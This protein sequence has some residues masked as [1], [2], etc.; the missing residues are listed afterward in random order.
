MARKSGLGKGLGALMGDAVLESGNTQGTETVLQLS[1]MEP[2]PNQPR[3]NF[4][5]EALESLTDSIKKEG[6]LQPIL[7]R[8][9]GDT[10]Q[11]VAGERRYHAC[12]NAGL[13]E[14]PVRIVEMDDAQT[15]RV[16]LI[17]N[18]Q[19]SDLNAIEEAKGY[20]ELMDSGAVKTQAEVAEA[21]SKSRSAVTNALRLLELPE[22]V[23]T[24]VYD[25]KL[26]AGHARAILA[27]KEE[28]QQ[29]KLADKIVASNLSVRDAERLARLSNATEVEKTKKPEVP[30]S[31]KLVAK[32]L[33]RRLSTTVRVK[34]AKG[35]NRI[36]ID[37][38][39]EDD[40]KRI[41]DIMKRADID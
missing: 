24:L 34:A 27:V 7:V 36:E 40:L 32:E 12:K 35:K 39:D 5:K 41:F 17:E 22:Y 29:V 4:E 26:S 25:G 10:Y 21:V 1:E 28:S 8:K 6:L 38:A 18:L 11:I 37:F 30:K 19:R 16:A 14:V 33:K 31:Y 13:T 9:V 2:N 20:K 15:L 3:T 23:Q